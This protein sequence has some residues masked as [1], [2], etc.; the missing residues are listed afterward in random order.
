MSLTA[1]STTNHMPNKLRWRWSLN[2]PKTTLLICLV[3]MVLLAMTVGGIWKLWQQTRAQEHLQTEHA[4]LALQLKRLQD[5]AHSLTASQTGTPFEF[6]ARKRALDFTRDLG[7]WSD[8][9]GVQ[10]SKLGLSHFATTPA[11]Q[12][13]VQLDLT[14]TGPYAPTKQLLGMLM[15]RY[16]SLAIQSLNIHSR[17]ADP[18][19]QDWDLTLNLYVK[20]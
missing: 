4:D 20:D 11:H 18:N 13:R 17:N 6:P 12:G 2:L 14:L 10:V 15:D 1:S 19:R 8:K 5:D 16:D 3:S 9:Q 7:N